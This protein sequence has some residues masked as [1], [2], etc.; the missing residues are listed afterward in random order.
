MRSQR[1]SS[2]GMVLK[3]H[4]NFA[5]Y[6]AMLGSL[7]LTTLVVQV[8]PIANIFHFEPLPWDAY[9]ISLGLAFLIIPIVEIIKLFQRKFGKNHN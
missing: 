8:A 7:A 4:H 3:G 2:I 1:S 6:G 9:F 5:L